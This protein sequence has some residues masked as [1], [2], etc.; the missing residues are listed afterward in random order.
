MMASFFGQP[1]SN[2]ASSAATAIAAST[3]RCNTHQGQ[4][5]MP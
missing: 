4:G 5:C 3:A 2:S 1:G